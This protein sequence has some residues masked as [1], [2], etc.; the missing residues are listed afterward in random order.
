[1]STNV[2]HDQAGQPSHGPRFDCL[3]VYEL[4]AK[5]DGSRQLWVVVR[6]DPAADPITRFENDNVEPARDQL[7]RGGKTR[8][9]GPDNDDVDAAQASPRCWTSG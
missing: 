2:G 6:P 3:G 5:F 1:M 7:S 8:Y 4:R 9:A